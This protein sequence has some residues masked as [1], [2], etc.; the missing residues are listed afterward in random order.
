[1]APPPKSS[2]NSLRAKPEL[3]EIDY[4]PTQVVTEYFLKV[5]GDGGLA[6]GG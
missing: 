2:A 3:E 6:G 5:F 4:V 1:V